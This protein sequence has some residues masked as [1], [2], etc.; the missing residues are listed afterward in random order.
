MKICFQKKKTLE[1]ILLLLYRFYKMKLRIKNNRES[2]FKTAICFVIIYFISNTIS[3]AQNTNNQY[4][5]STKTV[6][7]NGD[8]MQ[9]YQTKPI[10]ILPKPIFANNDDLKKFRKLIRNVKIVY[11]YA[12]LGKRIFQ[13]LQCQLDTTPDKKT[14]NKLIKQK[15]KELLGQYE[16]ELKRLSVSQGQILIKLV[17][18]ELHR[19]SYEILK[20]MR[21]S[22]SAFMWQQLARLFGS[23]LKTGYDPEGEDKMIEK[24]II[25]IENGQL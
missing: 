4:Q 20:E 10:L 1:L 8:T 7:I 3:L 6:I 18:R 16:D 13:E 12:K 17:D 2:F 21:G 9:S 22:M 24:I 23:D 25:L 11:P 14:R 19:T 15:E 5:P